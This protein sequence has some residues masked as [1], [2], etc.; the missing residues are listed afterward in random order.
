MDP[1]PG[2]MVAAVLGKKLYPEM[3]LKAK[4]VFEKK[5]LYLYVWILAVRRF[6]SDTNSIFF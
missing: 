1:D 3:F 6:P 4:N 5:N 2:V